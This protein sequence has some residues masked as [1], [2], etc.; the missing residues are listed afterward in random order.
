[1]T[2]AG[3]SLLPYRDPQSPAKDSLWGF[4]SLTL[5]HL[6]PLSLWTRWWNNEAFGRF[7]SRGILAARTDGSLGDFPGCLRSGVRN[8]A[9]CYEE[10][11]RRF[12]TP[13]FV[14]RS[15][16]WSRS[17]GSRRQR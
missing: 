14:S 11:S 13:E 9:C 16:I 10:V 7:A 2:F 1:M 15:K 4:G 5:P 8:V 17:D 3:L 6:C 12:A